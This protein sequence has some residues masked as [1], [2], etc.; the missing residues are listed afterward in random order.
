MDATRADVEFTAEVCAIAVAEGAGVINI[1]DTVGYT[2]PEEYTRY[3]ERLYELVP[4]LRDV[5]ALG[6]LPRRPRPRGR[7][8]LRRSAG[9]GAPGRVRGQRDR[10][11][12]RQ[13]L[14]RGDR[15]A[16]ADA[17][18][19]ARARHGARQ[20]RDRAHE[21]HGLA[22][23]RLPVQPNKA[24]VGRN[25]FAHESGIHQDG[26]LKERTTYEI[27]DAPRSGWTRT[28]IVL[29]KHSGRHALRDALEQ[30]GFKVEGNALNQAFQR[31]KEI[32]DKKKHVTALD[33][34]AIVS[35]EFRER[36]EA[37][38]WPGS[39]SR[40]AHASE[41]HAQVAVTLP[42]GEESVGEA[43]GDGPVDA[44]F[45]AIQKAAETECELRQYTVAAVTEGE[46]ALGEVTVMLRAQAA[47][48]RARASPPTSS[49]RR[50]A[51]TCARSRTRSRARRSARPRRLPPRRRE[52]HPGPVAQRDRIYS[53]R[54][55]QRL[56][57]R[58]RRSPALRR[59]SARRPR[60]RC[61][62][63]GAAVALGARRKDRLDDLAERINADG[64]KGV[65]FEADIGEEEQARGVRRAGRR[66]ARRPRHPGQQRRR[67]A[68]RPG[69]GR[70]HRASGGGWSRSTC[71]GLLYC[72]HAALPLM[73]DGGGGH[74]VNVA[75]VA[76]RR[77]L[78]VG[79]LQP[80]QV[81]R[82][83]ASPRRCARR[84]CT[85]TSA[86]PASSPASWTPSCRAT[87][88]T[89]WSLEATEKMR[90]QIGKLLEAED[91]A[92]AI[93]YA[94]SSPST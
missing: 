45:D 31:F 14:A 86:S 89:R 93:L 48:R 73:R 21:P 78:G 80:H 79:R 58:S 8:L 49:R 55:G 46:D 81:G 26:V 65:A 88:S 2:T 94:V 39:R 66:G 27:M 17:P 13:L 6:P 5:R 52:R 91:I 69:P 61:A 33:L 16:A 9:G 3:F 40:P 36:A 90:E 11:A 19:R 20:P 10:R 53:Q 51:P 35:D 77:R 23:H 60:W 32:A 44:I 56:T 72:T 7:Q 43:T 85:R 87:T 25:A 34:E 24:I 41:P 62:A 12:R 47:S 18:R 28:Q 84:R 57:A 76:G 15:D 29:G 30:L 42:S 50:P 75:S 38:S 68:A 83:R 92:N 59:G 22:L 63:E 74:I 1:P 70:R 4:E 82:R 64:G 37:T 71:S 67:D 54:D